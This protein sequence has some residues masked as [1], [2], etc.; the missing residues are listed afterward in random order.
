MEYRNSDCCRWKTAVVEHQC[1][2]YQTAQFP[3]TLQYMLIDV[4]PMKQDPKEYAGPSSNEGRPTLC[5]SDKS[6][7]ERERE[8]LFSFV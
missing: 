4:G 8:Y 7:T 5:P 2:I 1:P 6:S 3:Y